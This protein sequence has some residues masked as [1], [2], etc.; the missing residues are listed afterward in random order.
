[1]KYGILLIALAL[2]AAALAFCM[3]DDT[4]SADSG[5]VGENIHWEYDTG[6]RTLTVTG[7]V[8]A[9]KSSFQLL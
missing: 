4:S 1:M 6:T 5:D 2:L 9:G 7:T 8:S 3:N